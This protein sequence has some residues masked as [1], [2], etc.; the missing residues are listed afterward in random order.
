MVVEPAGGVGPR[1]SLL[2]S[3]FW[4]FLAQIA[5]AALSLVNVL[6]VARSLG[7][8]GRGEVVFLTATAL[9]LQR[10][11]AFGVQ[12]ANVNFGG[13]RPELHARLATNSFLFAAVLGAATAGAMAVLIFLVPALGG[14]AS[15][16]LLAVALASLPLLLVQLYLWRLVQADYRF[17]FANLVWTL[18]SR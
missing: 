10:V 2:S 4:T 9:L 3:T 11:G 15:T 14:G 13:K 8:S 18:P 5:T 7:P 6:I 17:A 12:E 1:P 16:T